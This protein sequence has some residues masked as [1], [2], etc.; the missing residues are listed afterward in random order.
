MKNL[1]AYGIRGKV[2][3]WI[4]EF[5]NNRIQR[6]AVNGCY[7]N[8]KKVAFGIPQGSVLGTILFVIFINDLP[9]DIQ[10]VMSLYADDSKLIGN[11]KTI[12]HVNG[13]QVSLNNSVIWVDLWGMFYN[14]KKCYHLHIGN[15]F[16][17]TEYTRVTPDGPVRVEKVDQ[18]KDLGVIFHSNI[19]FG[20][21]ISSK[22]TKANQI[23][24][25]IFRTFT[26]MDREMFL[27]LYKSLIRPHVEYINMVTYIQK[28]PSYWQYSKT[29]NSTWQWFEA[30]IIS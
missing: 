27:N 4:K 21:L 26:Y 30:L 1:W 15:K 12:E 9:E 8:F 25:F 24:G 22:V 23:L 28:G 11:V 17:D 14:F 19:K 10:V 7:S 3:S 20:Q 29:S 13:I 2:H 16:T 6:V 18:D 5:L